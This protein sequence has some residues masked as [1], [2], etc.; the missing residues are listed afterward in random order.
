MR[1]MRVDLSV[2]VFDD[3]VAAIIAQDKPE[4]PRPIDSRP[5]IPHGRAHTL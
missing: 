1:G 4:D 2:P 3:E 5:L